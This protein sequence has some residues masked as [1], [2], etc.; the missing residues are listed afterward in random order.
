[1]KPTCAIIGS[2][3][4]TRNAFDFTR[5]DCDIWVFNEAM[6]NK[7][8]PRADVVFQIHAEPIWRNPANR[9][10]NGHV[11]WL[12]TQAHIPVLM[13][14][15]Y[16][17]VPMAVKYPL[18]G[19]LDMLDRDPAHLL[20]SSVALAIAYACYLG[21][22]KRI[23]VWGVA[24]ETNTEYQWQREGVA[25]WRGFAMGRGFKF[26]FADPTFECPIYGYEGKVTVEY[27]K[28][29]ERVKELEPDVEKLKAEYTAALMDTRK[30]LELLAKDGSKQIEEALF[31]CVEKQRTLGNR[32]G[33]IDGA[34]QENKRYLLKADAM[35][36]V[37]GEHIFSRQEFESGLASLTKKANELNTNYIACGANL[38]NLHRFTMNAAKNSPKRKKAL[39]EYA[40]LMQA[41]MNLNNQMAIYKGA[42]NENG[43]Y[44]NYLDK[45]IRAAG[46]EKSEAVLL[47]SAAARHGAEGAHMAVHA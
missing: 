37:A 41:Y 26:Y 31:T 25:F 20:S 47:E 36:E 35:R 24:M 3:P 17:D 33:F 21:T 32:L 5:E 29:V 13:Q 28:F 22:Y 15:Q 10:D 44:M 40:R 11:K 45:H 43:L 1:M 6:S 34:I 30:A 39:E 38:D 16:S 23:E 7:T 27:E 18:D 19:I 14:D 46:G 12:Q 9:N 8:F 4:R 42:A 2:H